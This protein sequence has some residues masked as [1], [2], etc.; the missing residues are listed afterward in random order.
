MYACEA[1]VMIMKKKWIIASTLCIAILMMMAVM[2]KVYIHEKW[3]SNQI[4]SLNEEI[5]SIEND[6]QVANEEIAKLK[7]DV[8]VLSGKKYEYLAD[9]FNYLAIGNS[10]TRHGKADYWWNE[11]GMAATRPENDYVHLIASHL[12]ENNEDVC[13]Y[14]V[15]FYKWENQAY[16]R[17]ETY[18]VIDPYLSDRL[19]LV[20]IQLS[21]NVGDMTTYKTDYVALI[22]Y[23]QEMA[24]E[25]QVLVIDDFWDSGDKSLQ[26]QEACE[27]T[28]VTFVSLS[29]IKGLPEYKCGM[30]TTVYDDEGKP[31]IVEHEGVAGHPGDKGMKAIADKVI[32]CIDETGK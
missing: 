12:E 6:L 1:E 15:N 9:G 8:Q 7:S 17:A 29:D 5:A 32:N 3:Q 25:A 24:P 31:H 16:D 30:G 21:E 10:I 2:T 18:E 11:I 26:K 14:A 23:V 27:E 19:D 4:H 20:T 28:G 13:F 22:K